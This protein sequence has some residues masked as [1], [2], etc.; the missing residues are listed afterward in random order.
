M[1]TATA[2]SG[3]QS[4]GTVRQTSSYVIAV[5]N[6]KGGVGKTMLT[7][8]LAAHSASANGRSLVVDVDPQ[9]TAS[10]LTAAM[11]D[12]GYDAVSELDPG[13]L[14]RISQL[15]DYDTI[16]VDSPGSL[17]HDAVLAR[18]L[19][20]ATIVLVPYTHKPEDLM[21]TL[22]TVRKAQDAGVPVGVVLTRVDPRLGADFAADAWATLESAGLQHF[23]SV[24]REYRAWPNSL[25]AGVP[26]TKHSERYAPH[27]REDVARLHTELLLAIGRLA[28]AAR[29]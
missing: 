10:D 5:V 1:N 9:G 24:I 26:I 7:L 25:Q 16:L 29:P 11:R 3:A 8:A 6:Q 21:P 15:R 2:T 14:G 28:P 4:P 17:E 22:R 27:V 12:P 23:R 13:E 19:K 20:A 18:I